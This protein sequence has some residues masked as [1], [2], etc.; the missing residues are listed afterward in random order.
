MHFTVFLDLDSIEIRPVS[1]GSM[2]IKL[3]KQILNWRA[4]VNC[5]S[6]SKSQV[7]YQI[8]D[9]QAKLRAHSSARQ[10]Q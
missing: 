3:F 4:V 6:W 8:S 10:Q 9:K 2:G 1:C 7:K 5:E